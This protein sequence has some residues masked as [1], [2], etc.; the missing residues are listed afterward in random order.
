M[1]GTGLKHM[2]CN[3]I[4]LPGQCEHFDRDP[5]LLIVPILSLQQAKQ[6]N[7]QGYHALF[8][9]STGNKEPGK[10]RPLEDVAADVHL[11]HL[12][13]VASTPEIAL[14]QGLL[15]A[16][17]KG[18]AYALI[19]K[20]GEKEPWV[21]RLSEDSRETLQTIRDQ[22]TVVTGKKAI[23]VPTQ[24]QENKKDVRKVTFAPAFA[25][26]GKAGHPAP[27][28]LLLAV[29]AAVNWSKF[30]GQQL[31]AG[32]EDD[33][34]DSDMV[35]EHSLIAMEKYLALQE[36]YEQATREKEIMNMIVRIS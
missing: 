25:S 13:E 2:I 15:S 21:T 28:P 16:T 6:W 34:S 1:P 4:R 18:L 26:P 9:I 12:G 29:K 7:G 17:I 32:G 31:M 36:H 10:G 30:H 5:R 35:S 11:Q 20:S 22:F 19:K 33:E 23:L 27:D 24:R 14:A 3:K 8:M